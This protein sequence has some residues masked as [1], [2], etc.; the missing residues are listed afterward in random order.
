MIFCFL[1]GP[2]LKPIGHSKSKDIK[3]CKKE[4]EHNI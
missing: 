1:A 3:M 4:L 2:W